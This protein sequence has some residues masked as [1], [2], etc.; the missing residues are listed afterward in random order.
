MG[1][2][3]CQIISHANTD[4]KHDWQRTKRMTIVGCTV[5]P[6][7]NTYFF[8]MLDKVIIGNSLRVVLFKVIIDTFAWAPVCITAFIGGK[9]KT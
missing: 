4:L 5:L 8:R 9:F 2:V 1:D 3:T 6:V 7:M